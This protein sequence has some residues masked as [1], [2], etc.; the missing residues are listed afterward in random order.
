MRSTEPALVSD[1]QMVAAVDAIPGEAFTIFDFTRT[2]AELYP[3]VWGQLFVVFGEKGDGR[4]RS[5]TAAVYL[6]NRLWQLTKKPGSPLLPLMKWQK[7]GVETPNQRRA[8]PEE[9]AMG[10]GSVVRVFRK[11]SAE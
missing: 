6:G 4:G 8:T 5:Y 2:F 7:G 11:R 10:A 3:E 1:Q 9:R